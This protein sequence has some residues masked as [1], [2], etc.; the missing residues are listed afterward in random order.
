MEGS[1]LG[2]PDDTPVSFNYVPCT[3]LVT[4]LVI[5]LLLLIIIETLGVLV[6]DFI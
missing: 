4:N 2:Y 3:N 5:S 1:I 6:G